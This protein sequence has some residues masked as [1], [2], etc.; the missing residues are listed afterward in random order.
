VAKGEQSI[1]NQ[2]QEWMGI[3]IHAMI[4]KATARYFY[5]SILLRPLKSK[6]AVVLTDVSEK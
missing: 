3:G 6:I 2:G 1:A 4:K 5:G